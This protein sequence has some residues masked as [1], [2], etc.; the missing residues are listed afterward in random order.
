MIEYRPPEASFMFLLKDVMGLLITC[1]VCLLFLRACV[2]L[3]SKKSDWNF[4]VSFLWEV[5]F[6]WA[7]SSLHCSVI[8]L[9]PY[10]LAESADMLWSFGSKKPLQRHQCL[11]SIMYVLDFLLFNALL[12]KFLL[13]RLFID[14]FV[15]LKYTHFILNNCQSNKD[16]SFIKCVQESWL[17]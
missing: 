11:V 12:G 10:F 13:N 6:S 2:L 1:S 3:S 8:V 5:S 14:F 17:T 9:F 15:V 4:S 16:A 7:V